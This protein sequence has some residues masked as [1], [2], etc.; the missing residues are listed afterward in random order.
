MKGWILLDP[1]RGS[2]SYWREGK[3]QVIYFLIPEK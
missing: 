2:M 1:E 3:G